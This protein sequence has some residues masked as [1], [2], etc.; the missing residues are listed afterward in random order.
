[1]KKALLIIG[2]LVVFLAPGCRS[3]EGGKCERDDD[4]KNQGDEVGVCY[5]QPADARFGKCMKDSEAKAARKRYL[6]KTTG[7]CG[8]KDEGL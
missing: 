6:C 4:C 5:K 2:L 1:M 7:K 8:D 3:P